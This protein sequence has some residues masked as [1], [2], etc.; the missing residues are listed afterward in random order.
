[1]PGQTLAGTFVIDNPGPAINLTKLARDQRTSRLSGCQPQFGVNLVGAKARQTTGFLAICVSAPFVIAS[2]TTLL[3]FTMTTWYSGCAQSDS[4]PSA[5][6]RACTANGAPTLPAGKYKTQL[7]W[8]ER[9]PLP[10]PQAVTIM[11]LAGT[12]VPGRTR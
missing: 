5:H 1:V 6:Y 8:S 10:K 12:Y 11:L 2:G 4:H 9:V 7:V 3:P